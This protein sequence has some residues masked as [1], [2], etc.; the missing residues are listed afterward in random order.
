MTARCRAAMTARRAG[1][2]Q[3]ELRDE[4]R[5]AFFERSTGPP[6]E[7][8]LCSCRIAD[9]RSDVVTSARRDADRA[10]ASGLDGNLGKFLERGSATGYQVQGGQRALAG[11]QEFD[12]R[13]QPRNHV[14]DV[15]EVQG[16]LGAVEPQRAVS[17]R[18]SSER[19]RHSVV[20]IVNGSVDA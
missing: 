10:T 7:H 19:G 15:S 5:D 16:G 6:A 20:M 1:L 12:R 8:L 3:T 18:E 11:G 13:P 14:T 2:P 9:E 4:I 17:R